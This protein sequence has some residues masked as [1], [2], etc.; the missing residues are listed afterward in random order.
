M[1]MGKKKSKQQRSPR[2]PW[3][4]TALLGALGLVIAGAAAFWWL[5]EAQDKSGGTPRLVLDRELVDLGYLRFETPVRVVF[6][7]TN[8]GDGLLRLTD[9]P[10]VKV[11]K[12]C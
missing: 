11:L 6:M 1:N 7:L 2:R 5:S 8:T 9:V 10:K 3:W 4:R 12:G